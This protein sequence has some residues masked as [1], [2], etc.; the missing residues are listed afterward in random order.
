MHEIFSHRAKEFP[1]GVNPVDKALYLQLKCRI[2]RQQSGGTLDSIVNLGVNVSN[3]IGAPLMAL[4]QVVSKYDKNSAVANL[5][6]DDNRREE[7]IV[8]LFL[9]EENL[10]QYQVVHILECCVNSEV[11]EYAGSQWIANRADANELLEKAF[12][13]TSPMVQ[14][15]MVVAS[16]KLLMMHE[17]GV[18]QVAPVAK[19]YILRRYEDKYCELVANRYRFKYK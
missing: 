17:R 4:K 6:W 1:A 16:A 7:Q 13:S 2:Y 9:F 5:L 18:M 10:S 14:I 12:S 19:E 8:A 3:Q 11:A 15:A